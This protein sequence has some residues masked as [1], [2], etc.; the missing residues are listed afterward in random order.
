MQFVSWKRFRIKFQ[1]PPRA[2]MQDL[3]SISDTHHFKTVIH[4]II[5]EKS[6]LLTNRSKLL[7]SF[8]RDPVSRADHEQ[9]R[10]Q[11]ILNGGGVPK[12]VNA[13]SR[14]RIYGPMSGPEATSRW[15]LGGV[16]PGNFETFS[17]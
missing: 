5:L 7:T 15:R 1:F 14:G 12:Q 2:V 10:R 3:R 6:P 9:G 4:A 17:K 11:G 16:A 8:N 13:G